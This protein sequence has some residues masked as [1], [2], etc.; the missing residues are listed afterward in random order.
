[1]YPNYY[2]PR[3]LKGLKLI[4]IGWILYIIAL[5]ILLIMLIAMIPFLMEAVNNPEDFNPSDLGTLFVGIC[6]S[7]LFYMIVAILFLIGIIFLLSG[8]EE[9]GVQHS[10]R[11]LLGFILIIIGF[12]LSVFSYIT[13]TY[14][15]TRGTIYLSSAL[16]IASSFS[17][18]LG[19][20]FL[21]E[22]LLDERWQRI[23][24]A[25]GMIYIIFGIIASSIFTWFFLSVGSDLEYP[26]FIF[27]GV[28]TLITIFSGLMAMYL[29]PIFIFFLCYR[30]AEHRIR[31]GE[32]KLVQPP[33]PPPLPYYYP[34]TPPAYYP[35]PAYGYGY[36]YGYPPPAYG[37]PTTPPSDLPGAPGKCPSCNKDIPPGIPRCPHCG[38]HIV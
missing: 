18:A 27:T 2:E 22:K 17:M 11:V 37:Y 8:R 28:S 31:T 33:Y 16:S 23:L 36:G 20:V 10:S 30:Q 9:F 38:F 32:L 21:V 14:A 6:L 3:T 26:G 7:G 12:I 19:F 25:G 24:W 1:M 29:L 5:I 4:N 35:P 34:P 13:S 15:I